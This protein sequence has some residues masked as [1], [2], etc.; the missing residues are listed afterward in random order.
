MQEAKPVSTLILLKCLSS[1][2]LFL[3]FKFVSSLALVKL[4]F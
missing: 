1:V 4:T 2:F 3:I